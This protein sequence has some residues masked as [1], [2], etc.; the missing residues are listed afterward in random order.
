VDYLKHM[1]KKTGLKVS[2]EEIEQAIEDLVTELEKAPQMS[3]LKTHVGDNEVMVMKFYNPEDGKEYL[4]INVYREAEEL[5]L[6][7][8]DFNFL[9]NKNIVPFD[10]C[11]DCGNDSE[12]V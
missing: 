12:P 3:M 6:R 2:D 4:K 8:K 11:K 5:R 1:D 10:D 9:Y 7:L